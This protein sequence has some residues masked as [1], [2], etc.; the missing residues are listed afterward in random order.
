MVG[1]VVAADGMDCNP[2]GFSLLEAYAMVATRLFPAGLMLQHVRFT[3]LLPALQAQAQFYAH[4]MGLNP[5]ERRARLG[6]AVVMEA[7]VLLALA[8]DYRK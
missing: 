5:S 7:A 8:A 2:R 6:M 1:S 3:P 4:G